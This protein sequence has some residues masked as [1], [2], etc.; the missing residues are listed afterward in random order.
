MSQLIYLFSFPQTESKKWSSLK[1]K[2]KKKK[3]KKQKKKKTPL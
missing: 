1:I 2:E 3:G